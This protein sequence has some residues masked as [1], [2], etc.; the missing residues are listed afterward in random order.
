MGLLAHKDKHGFEQVEV[1]EVWVGVG[2]LVKFGPGKKLGRPKL[3]S[4]K[5][6]KSDIVR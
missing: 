1:N 4:R 3:N 2:L 5:I 6:K